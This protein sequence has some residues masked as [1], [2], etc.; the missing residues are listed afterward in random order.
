MEFFNEIG[1]YCSLTVLF[2]RENASDRKRQ[3][4]SKSNHNFEAIFL[5]GIKT[6]KDTAFCPSIVKWIKKREFDLCIVGL[7]SSLTGI[8]AINTLKMLRVP[9]IISSD[10]GFIKEDSFFVGRIKR[11]LI[12]SANW[13]LS[14]GVET[15]RYLEHYGAKSDNIYIY[16]FTSIRQEHINYLPVSNKEKLEMRKELGINA[17]KMVLAVGQFIYRKGFETLISSWVEMPNDTE[18]VLIG[19]P[20]NDEYLK[21]LNNLSIN[22]VRV[23][24]FIN[25]N[26]LTKYYRASDVFVLPTREDIWGL[27]INEAM[28]IGLPIV[29]T[30]K[31]IAGL[32]LVRDNEN[33]F[34]VQVDNY[35]ELIER[36]KYV[37]END[38]L[39]KNMSISSLEKI[40]DYTVEN[41]ARRHIDIFSEILNKEEVR[42]I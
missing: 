38:V 23:L 17:S 36:I 41:M 4:F 29:S 30:N 12:G 13:W 19:G 34:I 21:I 32:E 2:E 15:N 10:G 5:K 42:Y 1:K 37:L 20:K 14:T 22:N 40:K 8:L 18:L 33:G 39:T 26:E 16:P 35:T 25:F 6:G 31:C 9:F 28:A 11:Y 7:Y 3:W 27:V 24:D